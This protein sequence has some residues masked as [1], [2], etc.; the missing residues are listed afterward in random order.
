MAHPFPQHFFVLAALAGGII[1]SGDA[2]PLV[3]QE[4]AG[5]ET[6]PQEEN[7]EEPP[8]PVEVL[9]E[10]LESAPPTENTSD[11][12]KVAA[13]AQSI[14]ETEQHLQR[15]RQVLT[16]QEQE[17]KAATTSF[18]DLDE[19]YEQQRAAAEDA[20]QPDAPPTELE[21]R[22]QLAEERLELAV[23]GR[24]NLQE[25]TR[26]IEQ[27]LEQERAAY[28]R[29]TSGEEYE[30]PAA[31]TASPQSG[32]AARTN[33]AGNGTPGTATPGMAAP[34]QSPAAAESSTDSPSGTPAVPGLPTLAAGPAT[35]TPQA[36]IEPPPAEVLKAQEE[37]TSAQREAARAEE[38]LAGVEQRLNI[39]EREIKLKRDA[40]QSVRQQMQNAEETRSAQQAEL[41]AK[42]S[43]AAPEETLQELRDQIAA[44]DARHEG[45]NRGL[46]HLAMALDRLQSQRAVLLAEQVATLRA[47]EEKRREAEAK[48]EDF[49]ELQDPLHPRNV[50]NWFTTRGPKILWI[51]LAAVVLHF[52]LWVL[53]PKIV[54]FSLRRSRR[55]DKQDRKG[56]A[57]TIVDTFYTTA[58]AA[59]YLLAALTALDAAGIPVAP[60]LGGAAVVGL[61]VAFAAQNLIKDYFTGFMILV[62]DQYVVGDVVKITGADI[63]GISGSVERITLRMTALRDLEGTLHFIPHGNVTAVSNLTHGWS[64]AVFDIRLPY[65]EDPRPAIDAIIQLGHELR[66]DPELGELILEDLEMLGVDTFGESA[67]TVKFLIKTFPLQ[68]WKVKREMLHRIQ[69]RFEEL[70]IEIPYPHRTILYRP[71]SDGHAY[72]NHDFGGASHRK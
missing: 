19:Q 34:P 49:E 48:L 27:K 13:L 42:T 1:F 54:Y 35:T 10:A 24:R 50:I 37:A 5:Q 28:D 16:L 67:I 29:L 46:Q 63:P 69:R 59:I 45:A 20:P 43:E 66:E 15:L 64:R 57:Q 36:A 31:D 26:L 21:R 18:R 9:S 70:D 39:L 12:E 62:E 44:S 71:D 40:I 32:S 11:A 60:L 17:V 33:G 30:D 56:R 25:Q 6:R 41:E 3:A 68:Q 51:I 47:A 8:P 14:E 52:L 4:T 38:E 61:A 72:P 53:R 2:W 55:G 65:R 23:Q 7:G 58:T 22:R